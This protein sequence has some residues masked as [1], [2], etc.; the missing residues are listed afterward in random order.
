MVFS[1]DPVA[2]EIRDLL[3][4]G[5]RAEALTLFESAKVE[6]RCSREMD[7][8]EIYLKGARR[9]RQPFGAKHLW[10]EIGSDNDSLRSDG[11]SYAERL[12]KLSLKYR[13]SDESKIKMAISK[14]ERALEETR[15]I[16]DEE[17]R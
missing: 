13:M 8:L 16:N 1:F 15:R 2:N 3:N 11:V 9:G 7:E 10:I 17:N 5:Q 6:G 14:Y 4:R 12:E